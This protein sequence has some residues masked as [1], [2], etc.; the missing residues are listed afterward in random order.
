MLDSFLRQWNGS[1]DINIMNFAILKIFLNIFPLL[2]LIIIIGQQNL[3]LADGLN[4][5]TPETK[6]GFDHVFHCKNWKPL[7]N[8]FFII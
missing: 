7:L 5:R 8:F 4:D 2:S 6:Q 1:E 3:F